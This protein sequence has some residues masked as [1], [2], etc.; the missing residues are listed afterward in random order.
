ME[1][2]ARQVAREPGTTLFAV[3]MGPNQFFNNDNKD[4]DI[5]LLAALTGNVG[6]ISG[7]VGSYAGNYR[8]A[9]FNGAPQ[10]INENPFDLELDPAKPARPKQYWVPESAHYYNHED[11]PLRVGNKLLTGATHMPCPTKS[12]WFANANSILGNVKWHYNTV[13]NA[14]PRIEMI[15]VNEWWWTTSCEWADVVFGVDS[16]CELKHPDMTASVTNPFLCVFPRTTLPRIFHTMGDIEVMALV[17]SRLA[18]LTKDERFNDC[19][20]FVR[21]G[22][23][24]VYLQRI[25]DF[26]TNTKGY[27][28]ADLEAMAQQ[29]IPALMNNRTIPKTVGYEQVTDSQPWYTKTGRLE[30]YREENEFIEAGENLPVH[31]EPVDSTFYEPNVIVAAPHEA[32]RPDG[33]EKYG[34]KLDDLSCETRCGR[35]VVKTWS[36]LKTSPHPLIKD[37]YTFVFHT[38]KYRHG[39]HTMPIDTDM[40]AVLFGPFGDLHRQDKRM[41]FVAEGYVDMHPQDARDIGV[42]DGDYVWIDGDPEDRPFRGWQKNKK[43]YAFARLLCRARYYPGTPRGVTRMWFNMYGAT[44][45]SQQGQAERKDGL[46][47]N[48]RTGY[49]AMFRSGSHQSATRGWLKPTWMT[50]SLVRKEMFGQGIGKGFLPDVHCPTGAP[51]EAI[52]KITKAE[53]GGMEGKGLWRPAELGIRPTY[54]NEAMQQYLA[55]A[56]IVAGSQKKES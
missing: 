22:R 34:V 37:G 3:G 41:P 32:L 36:Q 33:P 52:V 23:T 19:W 2:L 47:K 14:L 26:S 10:Y 51:R 5:F 43:D 21:E 16:W 25:L 9:M 1:S 29:G 12:M 31:R 20:K 6:K 13:V 27:Q 18:E 49:Q 8:V 38:P 39:A 46:A 54:E 42:Q 11:H 7:N 53:P 17:A 30:F 50:D 55:G 56:F 24:D 40:I 28:F 45:G 44:P 48:P 4:R 35:N 15:C